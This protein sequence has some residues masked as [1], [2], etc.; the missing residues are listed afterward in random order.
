MFVIGLSLSTVNLKT[1]TQK[2]FSITNS[3]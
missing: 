3:D 2:F 1:Q